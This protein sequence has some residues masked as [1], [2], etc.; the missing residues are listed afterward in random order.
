[1]KDIGTAPCPVDAKQFTLSL[2]ALDCQKI[3]I[4][5]LPYIILRKYERIYH[6]NVSKY[7]Y[8]S[9]KYYESKEIYYYYLDR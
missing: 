2:S 4:L 3:F 7:I 5:S 8:I 9:E 1:M 6:K